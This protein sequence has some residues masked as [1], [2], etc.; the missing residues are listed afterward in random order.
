MHCFGSAQLNLT[1]CYPILLNLSQLFRIYGW[2][3]GDM[4]PHT[5]YVS[6]HKPNL[7][8]NVAKNTEKI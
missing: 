4:N 7:I 5:L 1:A 3:L 8:Q 2:P 6:S